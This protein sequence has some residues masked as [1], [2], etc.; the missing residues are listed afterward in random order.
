MEKKSEVVQDSIA[1]RGVSS[2]AWCLVCW[3]RLCLRVTK[4]HSTRLSKLNALVSWFAFLTSWHHRPLQERRGS[5]R[6]CLPS[7]TGKVLVQAESSVCSHGG[8]VGLTW[9][10][11]SESS[12]TCQ[13]FKNLTT[14]FTSFVS[15]GRRI[16]RGYWIFH[17]K[18]W[19]WNYGF[20]HQLKKQLL[21]W[22]DLPILRW[23]SWIFHPTTIQGKKFI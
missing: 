8:C 9:Y 14:L 5:S 20:P 18:I 16:K 15:K 4:K 12:S 10:I 6:K 7:K 13:L 1:Y 19:E 17:R 22:L 3:V 23:H 2:E 11:C 21:K